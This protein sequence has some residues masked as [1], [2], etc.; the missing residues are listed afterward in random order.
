MGAGRKLCPQSLLG[1]HMNMKFWKY[2]TIL[3]LIVFAIMTGQLYFGLFEFILAYDQTYITFI[4]MGVLAL[5]HLMLAR[6]HWLGSTSSNQMIRYMGDTTV[7]LGL[8]G[9]L[10]GFMVVLWSVFGPGV[11]IDPSDIAAMTGIITTMSQ[12]MA[13]ALITSLS[14][15]TASI[16]INLQLVI[17][18][19]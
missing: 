19:E 11:V 12:G 9:T 10:I 1:N 17:L 8:I 3:V 5:A 15:L 6:K 14:G 16:I 7:A 4:N 18:E 13:A 2:W